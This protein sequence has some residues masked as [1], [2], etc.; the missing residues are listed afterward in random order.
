[1]PVAVTRDAGDFTNVSVGFVVVSAG[2]GLSPVLDVTPVSGTITFLNGQRSA[3]LLLTAVNDETPEEDEVF[4]VSLFVNDGID[5][6]IA[7]GSK[8]IVI[9][10][11]DAPLRFAQVCSYHLL[12]LESV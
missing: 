5:A 1:M 3:D 4:S 8:T 10:R 2:S 12:H 6:S 7:V 11:N 9:R